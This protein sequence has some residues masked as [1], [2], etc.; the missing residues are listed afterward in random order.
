MTELPKNLQPFNEKEDFKLPVD[1]TAK[2]EL[3]QDNVN[4]AFEALGLGR[5]SS[6]QARALRDLG[7][8]SRSMGILET[9]QGTTLVSQQAMVDVLSR[10]TAKLHEI[11]TDSSLTT[12]Q[13]YKALCEV[14]KVSGYTVGQLSKL[15]SS[16]VKSENIIVEAAIEKD[17][18]RRASF[19]AGRSITPSQIIDVVPSR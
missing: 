2:R 5:I 7:L 16:S 11:E 19:P 13:K 14:A 3:T 9:I 6:D 1:F 12:I 4:R 18:A 17:K 15:N 8:F 10:L